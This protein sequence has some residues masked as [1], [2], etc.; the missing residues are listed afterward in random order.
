[1]TDRIISALY[2]SR[3]E[4]DRASS[5][6]RSLGLSSGDINIH[7]QDAT[8]SGRHEGFFETLKELFGAE[9]SH[10][11]AEGVR[12][13]H[14]LLTARVPD[15]YAD[16]AIAVLERSS[17]VD[18]DS[19]QEEWR[20]SGWTG[21][22]TGPSA[23]TNAGLS[24][25]ETSATG[26]SGAA[27]LSGGRQEEVIPVVEES[28]KVGKREVNRGG[29]RVRSYVVEEPVSEQVNLREEHVTV[30]RRAV[31]EPVRNPETLLRDRTIEVTE[32]AEEAVVAKDAVVREEVTVR[33]DVGERTKDIQDTVR[34]T[35]VEVEDSRTGTTGSKTV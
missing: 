22:Y 2:D 18:F 29:V 27:G 25:S 33:K 15:S 31:N 5:E 8:S 3:A 1:M 4:A 30:E 35:K 10:A 11:Y 24:T 17:A 20:A 14:Y 13:G 21:A 6:L 19:R 28:L 34:R 16:Q 23:Y 26:L 9:D 12:R 32:T 7:E